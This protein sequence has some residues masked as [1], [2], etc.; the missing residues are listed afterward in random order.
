M[1]MS[2]VVG[3]WELG[4]RGVSFDCKNKC[5]EDLGQWDPHVFADGRGM[6]MMNSS[7]S[8]SEL[9]V[10]RVPVPLSPPVPA[11]THA[12]FCPTGRRVPAPGSKALCSPTLSSAQ[13]PLSAVIPTSSFRAFSA[14]HGPISSLVPSFSL[15]SFSLPSPLPLP[16]PLSNSLKE[17]PVSCPSWYHLQTLFMYSRLSSLLGHWGPSSG[18]CPSWTVPARDEVP[19]PGMPQKSAVG[20]SSIESIP[21]EKNM[22]GAHC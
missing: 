4:G 2:A 20:K 6:R 21:W 15:I 3:K 12:V 13:L 19:N 14:N 22:R 9:I 17:N 16:S 10:A 11:S 5:C 18:H 8:P 7:S 1:Q